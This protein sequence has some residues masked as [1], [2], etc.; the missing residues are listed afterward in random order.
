MEML[1]KLEVLTNP[2]SNEKNKDTAPVNGEYVTYWKSIEQHIITNVSHCYTPTV[3]CRG[4]DSF[5]SS[6]ILMYE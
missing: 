5:T 2:V 6:F 3:S 4:T 1:L